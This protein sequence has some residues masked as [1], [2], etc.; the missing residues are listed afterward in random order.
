MLQR[1]RLS[2]R[3]TLLGS[4]VILAFSIVSATLY[5]RLKS[6]FFAEKYEKTQNLVESAST[7]IEHFVDLQRSGELSEADAQSSAKAAIANL[8]YDE[9]NYFWINDLEPRMIM[10]PIKPQ[11]DGQNLSD[12]E[13][14]NGKRLFVEM[15]K[16]ARAEGN[17]FVDYYW[18][19]PGQDAPAPK[20]SY[21]SLQPDWGWVVGSGIYVDDV[22]S[23]L[24]SFFA[25]LYGAIAILAI[26]SA[27]AF[28]FVARGISDPI[29]GII[30]KIEGG[31]SRIEEV[32][33]QVSN[34]SNR[35]AEEASRQ[36][37]SIASTTESMTEMSE[38]TAKTASNT[39]EADKLMADSNRILEEATGSM[40][41]L[42][43]SMEAI[44]RS[45][46]ETSQIVNTIDEIAF[47]T[48]ILALNAAV[49]A[50]RAGESGAGFAVVA[51]E[52]R[53]LAQRSAKAASDTGALIKDTVSKINEGAKLVATTSKSFNQASENSHELKQLLSRIKEAA[54]HQDSR[55]HSINTNVS[56]IEHITQ[57]NAANA[58][59]SAAATMEL[60]GQAAQLK[61][62]IEDLS[63]IVHGEND[64]PSS[65][66]PTTTQANRDLIA[67]RSTGSSRI[68]SESFAN[69]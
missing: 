43:T 54:E 48:N 32:A 16:V 66:S 22:E 65:S 62:L 5:P 38:A 20:I 28:Y 39:A 63:E 31:S 60:Q 56:S 61:Q 64:S 55:I 8:L 47:Q 41:R 27:L 49:E 1:Y 3:I 12:L 67:K 2:V 15:V 69:R 14:P 24:F 46:E 6:M 13:D 50:A 9:S 23:Q 45:S 42:T 68:S 29:V 11:L 25:F 17:G 33:I 58:E 26:V 7:L 36:A 18:P 59:E 34:C 53:A 37:G 40:D 52:V 4:L 30:D 21:V 10:H 19:K 44:T 57:Q 51:D 35:L